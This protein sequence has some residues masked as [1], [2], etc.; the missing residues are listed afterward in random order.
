MEDIILNYLYILFVFNLFYKTIIY[1]TK[2]NFN[3][4]INQN[5]N[6]FHIFQNILSH[7]M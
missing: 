2:Y 4:V 7:K 5:F 3:Y 6:N 1:L